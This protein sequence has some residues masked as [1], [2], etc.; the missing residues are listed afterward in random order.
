MYKKT[1]IEGEGVS[2]WLDYCEG[3]CELEGIEDYCLHH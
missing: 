2:R 3:L 1:L